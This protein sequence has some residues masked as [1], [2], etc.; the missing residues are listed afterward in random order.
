MDKINIIL[1][2]YFVIIINSNNI[3]IIIKSTKSTDFIDSVKKFN[4]LNMLPGKSQ[5]HKHIKQE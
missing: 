1:I 5:L 2:M 4:L 3:I